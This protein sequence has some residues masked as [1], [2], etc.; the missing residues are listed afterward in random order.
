[1]RKLL[2][3][4]LI[5][6]PFIASAQTSKPFKVNVAVGYAATADYSNSNSI[7]KAGFVYN[8]EPQY[9]VIPNL[10]IGL[11]LEQAFAQRPEYIDESTVFQT[12][13]KSIMSGIITANYSINVGG[14]IQPFIGV[15]GGLYYAEPSAQSDTRFGITTQY[16]LPTTT[17]AG[18]MARVGVRW[19]RVN[20]LADYNLVTDTRVTVSATNRSLAAK[21]SYFSVKA[22]FIIGGG[23]DK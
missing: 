18:G 17:V 8:L 9:R 20:L 10:D 1:M 11:R 13:T 7:R 19:G 21:N 5:L 4:A 2:F 22:G 14:S 16:P 3:S 23:S 6:V 15:G 12:K